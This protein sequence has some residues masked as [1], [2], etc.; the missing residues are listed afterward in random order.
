MTVSGVN[1]GKAAADYATFRAGVPDSFFDRL[2]RLGIGLPG[3]DLVDL[4]TGTGTLARGFVRRGCRVVGVDPDARMLA[5]ARALDRE[6]GMKIAYVEAKAEATGLTSASADVV[7]AGQ[8]W[9]WFDRPRALD[10]VLRVLRN[11]GKLVIAHF[12]AAAAAHRGRGNG[13]THRPLQR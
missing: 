1:F 5:A 8:C 9:H 6:H 2:V 10:E 4:G 11:G 3:Q 12:D 13:A 7:A